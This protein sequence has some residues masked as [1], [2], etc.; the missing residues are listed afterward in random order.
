MKYRYNKIVYFSSGFFYFPI[1]TSCKPDKDKLNIYYFSHGDE[2][3]DGIS[4]CPNSCVLNGSV[5]DD[6]HK[7]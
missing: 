7:L 3:D 2:I 5:D 6:I 1:V 4:L